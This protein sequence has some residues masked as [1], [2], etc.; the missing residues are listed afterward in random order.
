MTIEDILDQAGVLHGK[1]LDPRQG[2]AFSAVFGLVLMVW[3]ADQ[4]SSRTF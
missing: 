3:A 2:L 4:G 1:A